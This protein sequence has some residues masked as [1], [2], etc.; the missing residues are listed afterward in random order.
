MIS[1]STPSRFVGLAS[2]ALISCG[3]NEPS[4]LGSATPTTSIAS[5]ALSVPSA[6]SST[7]E[8]AEEDVK[9]VYP[10]TS[11]PPLP[12]AQKYCDLAYELA[13]QKRKECCPNVSFFPVRPTEECVRTLSYA[14]RSGAVALS[15]ADL[16]TCEAAVTSAAK[17]CDW[18]GAWP[19]G[20]LG[21]VHGTREERGEC[22]SSLECKEGMFC[23][24]LGV[25]K[26][27]KCNPS[28]PDGAKCGGVVDSLASFI[29]QDPERVNSPCKGTC[30][31]RIC[32][33]RLKA[34]DAC[35]SGLQCVA[36][37]RCAEGKC[38]EGPLPKEGPC[39]GGSCAEGSRCVD[40]QC[41]KEL[42]IGDACTSAGACRSGSC[43]KGV[44]TMKCSLMPAPS[45]APKSSK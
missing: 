34:G 26:P 13:E 32:A 15:D 19:D 29:K 28:L 39:E 38:T 18:G 7:E 43:E 12:Q 11:D 41:V 20:C 8:A 40:K 9:P 5:P 31:R 25:S 42:R 22:R 4:N 6:A 14:L 45:A 27:G 3:S 10:Q 33:P 30:N 44:C 23:A 35:Q 36:G 21:I 37:A 2:V 1:T 17:A 16:S 24:G